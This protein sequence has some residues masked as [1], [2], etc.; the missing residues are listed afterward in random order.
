MLTIS[1]ESGATD[2]HTAEA[3]FD[4]PSDG[5]CD[6]RAWT[7]SDQ[8]EHVRPAHTRAHATSWFSDGMPKG[9]WRKT[10]LMWRAALTTMEGQVEE[11]EAT[12]RP[13]DRWE[14]GNGR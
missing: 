1:T 9:G 4:V 2:E 7:P 10:A 8:R 6:V 5:S 13:K 11:G 14:G 12:E 3:V